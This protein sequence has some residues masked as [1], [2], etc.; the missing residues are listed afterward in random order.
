MSAGETSNSS[1]SDASIDILDLL[2][3]LFDD[4]QTLSG[5][6]VPDPS[7]D[8]QGEDDVTFDPNEWL[9]EDLSTRKLRAPR[10]HEFLRLLLNNLRYLSYASW[11]NQ[12][13]GLFKVHRPNDVAQLWSKVKS[14]QASRVMN[15]DTF[16]R[17]IRSYYANGLMI[18]TRTKYT[19]RFAMEKWPQ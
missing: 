12:S 9:V 14:R 11:T 6:Q 16:A 5:E 1:F 4:P 3:D 18:A 8:I 10:L 15:Y 17:G 13:K 19:Y 2:M 7:T